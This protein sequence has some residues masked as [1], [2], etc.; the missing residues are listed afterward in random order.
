MSFTPSTTQ[1]ANYNLNIRNMNFFAKPEIDI[2]LA[3][4]S[5]APDSYVASFSTLDEIE[6]FATIV[7]K[8]DT[9]FDELQISFVGLTNTF[10]DKMSSS[11]TMS[12]RT[13]AIHRFLKLEQPINEAD[14]PQSRI[15]EAGKEY[16][17]PF[18]FVVPQQLLPLACVHKT[19]HPTIR[20]THLQ[21]PPSFGEPILSGFGPTLLDDM[22]PAMTKIT[23]GIKVKL[24]KDEDD[25][26][27]TIV[28]TMKK[29]RIKPAFDEQPP[30][31]IDGTHE[32]YCHRQEK[33]IR[34]GVLKGKL[35]RLVIEASQP[36]SFRLPAVPAG[37][38]IPA[39]STMAKVVLRFD[40][41]SESCPPPR[42]GSLSS[43]LKVCTYFATTPRHALPTRTQVNYDMTQGYVSDMVQLSSMCVA[44]V[45]WQKH[46]AWESP[47]S[48]RPSTLS[49]M[50]TMTI[51]SNT[52]S[53]GV[54]PDASST[55][56][57]DFFYTAS[58]LV[59][60]SLPTSKHL[61]PTFHTC[62]VT[63]QYALHLNLSTHGQ[64][65]GPSVNLKL[66]I[67]ISSEGSVGA[68]QRRR[69][70]EEA[71]QA[72]LDAEDT[73]QPR[74]IAPPSD[75]YLGHSAV[76]GM[77]E[78]PGYSSFQGFQTS[79]ASVQRAAVPAY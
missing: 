58:I 51:G 60:I 39:I 25:E 61:V 24:L 3:R 70:S 10:L 37:E 69:M 64:P 23:Y 48:R 62:L 66:P 33:T 57:G 26:M 56:K 45:D 13:K 9:K 44:S 38:E 43:K 65:L 31:D 46:E 19:T 41:A 30:I 20:D 55:Y 7:A 50:S 35:G 22:A 32:D 27:S 63:R 73:F 34:R 16:K 72:A 47:E 29:L 78:P 15:L 18:T 36:K 54:I 74:N 12:G 67:Q 76:G 79:R 5:D 53:P 8:K 28:E 42:L 2:S 1:R 6:G 4:S 59:P 49:T 77:A 14:L 11:T 68:V 52:L 71:V 40:P 21:L 17:F 75:E